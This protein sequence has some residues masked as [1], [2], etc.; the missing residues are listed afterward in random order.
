MADEDGR[1]GTRVVVIVAIVGLL[2]TLGAS[3]VGGGLTIVAANV[4]FDNQRSAESQDKRRE[5]YANYQNSVTKVCQVND[6]VYGFGAPSAKEQKAGGARI[7]A[8]ISEVVN[9]NGQVQLFAHSEE[10]RTAADE[11]TRKMVDDF[12]LICGSNEGFFESQHRLI[13]AAKAD[14]EQ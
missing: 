5:V 3:L 1:G 9:F 10:I 11:L 2:S 14:L 6:E 13:V 4:Q 8:A 12:D 7:E